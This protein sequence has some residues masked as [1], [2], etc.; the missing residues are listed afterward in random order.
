MRK[1]QTGQP[2]PRQSCPTRSRPASRRQPG[3]PALGSRLGPHQPCNSRPASRPAPPR[4]ASR[5]G[6]RQPGHT[7]GLNRPDWPNQGPGPTGPRSSS[8]WA[9][10]FRRPF[11]DLRGWP[12]GLSRG[13]AAGSPG[14]AEPALGFSVGGCCLPASA[15]SCARGVA[16]SGFR[17]VGLIMLLRVSSPFGD[18]ID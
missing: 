5:S 15:D 3:Q 4:P 13:T 12:S 16:G 10:A 14:S 6:L 2:V 8:V 18:T 1:S 17:G 7:P 11:F 9:G